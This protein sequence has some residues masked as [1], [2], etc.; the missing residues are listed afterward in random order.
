MKASLLLPLQLWFLP[1]LFF[2]VLLLPEGAIAKSQPVN[3]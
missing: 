3:N 2:A 1:I